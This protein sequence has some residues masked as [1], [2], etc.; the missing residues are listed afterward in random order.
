MGK[1][2]SNKM[3]KTPQRCKTQ[4]QERSD[5]DV[6][7]YVLAHSELDPV[8]EALSCVFIF[9]MQSLESDSERW[10]I[11]NVIFWIIKGFC[12]YFS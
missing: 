2:Q 10:I 5:S 1:E 11:S 6:N 4:L 7:N 9:K 8:S 3:E 12:F